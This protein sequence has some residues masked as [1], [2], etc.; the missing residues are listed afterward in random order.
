MAVEGVGANGVSSAASSG[1]SPSQMKSEDFF[2]LLIAELRYQDPFQPMDN[3]KMVEQ[4]AGIRNIEA[5]T[6][7]AS[8]ME[9]VTKNQNFSTAANMVGKQVGGVLTDNHGFE[10]VVEGVVE[11]VTFESNGKIVLHLDNGGTLPLEAVMY[12]KPAGSRSGSSGSSTQA[13]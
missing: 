10:Q 5:S 4:V 2:K 13:A 9:S 1:K 3:T 11:G 8:A 6:N 12:V 7:M